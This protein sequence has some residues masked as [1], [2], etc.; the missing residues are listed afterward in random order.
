MYQPKPSIIPV[1]IDNWTQTGRHCFFTFHFIMN[2]Q[3]YS[4]KG[5]ANTSIW[6]ISW[7]NFK[8]SGLS[9]EDRIVINSKLKDFYEKHKVPLKESGSFVGTYIALSLACDLSPS[10]NR[11]CAINFL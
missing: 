5:C 11:Y 10:F 4:L 8:G 9:E 1:L 7:D 6:A 2:R 3:V